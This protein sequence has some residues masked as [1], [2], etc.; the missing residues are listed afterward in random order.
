MSNC[1]LRAISPFPTVFSKDLYCRHLKPGLVWER[2]NSKKQVENNVGRGEIARYEQFF[3]FSNSI[4]KRLV[5]QT[6]K[7]LDLFG[8]WLI[9]RNCRLPKEYWIDHVLWEE[10]LLHLKTISTHITQHRNVQF[11][12]LCACRGPVTQSIVWKT[13]EQ[14]VAGSTLQLGQYSFPGLMK[15]IATGFIPL[16][17][18][19]IVSTMIMWESSQW[20]G[21]NI[22]R[23]TH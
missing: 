19:S 16:S 23:S 2:V 15:V 18:L 12:C 17:P 20:L 9:E 3:S 1:S 14:E 21:K 13:W 22:V 11:V 4:F 6:P 7:N 8:K 5:L 10:S